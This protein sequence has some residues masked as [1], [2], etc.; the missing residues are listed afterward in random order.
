MTILE[1]TDKKDVLKKSISDIIK[2][3]EVEQR[4]LDDVEQ[5]KVDNLISQIADLDNQILERE[6]ELRTKEINFNKKQNN[7]ENFKLLNAISAVVNNKPFNETE[8]T[9][10]EAGVNEMRKAG[11][12]YSGQI[13]LPVEQRA[14]LQATVLNQ[15]IENVP[16]DKWN[17]LWALRNQLVMVQSGALY[18]Q[19]LVGDVSIPVYSGSQVSWAGEI[20]MANDGAGTFSEVLLQPKRLTAYVDV[21]KQFLIQD[22]N[23]AEAMLRADIVRALRE[24]LE[25]TLLSDDA[26]TTT[27]PAGIGN[28]IP[29][30]TI[31][32]SWADIVSLE[33]ALELAN[34]YGDYKYVVAPSAKSTLRTMPKDAGSGLFVM[35]NQGING[36]G[37][38]STNSVFKNGII[39]GN[40]EDYVIGQWGAI[41]LVVD[42]Y[43]QAASGKVRLVINAYF[44]GKPRRNESFV[45]A[46]I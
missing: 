32:S 40:W 21:S 6:K 20:A 30:I 2:N 5:T 3:G 1:L 36:Y 34:V 10:I 29:P 39:V 17:I 7:M 12:S 43:T 22:S 37:V 9:V 28:I 15:G 38:H 27:Q 13:T 23:A 25:S 41:D 45:T 44:D 42:P 31:V 19:G 33:E 26:G 11:L 8:N 4:K 14:T 18:L 35:D 24:K 46:K 16:E